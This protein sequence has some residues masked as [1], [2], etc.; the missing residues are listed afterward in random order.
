MELILIRHGTTRGNLERRFIGLTDIPIL[1]E[2]EA[3]AREVSKTLPLVDH[4]YH[5]PLIRCVQTARLLWPDADMTAVDDLHE[6]DFGPFEG[7]SHQE[8]KDD[9]RY[10]AW[11]D[12]AGATAPPGGRGSDRGR[13]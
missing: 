1:P 6:T 13:P 12:S 8:L 9:P 5:S 7:K 3:L 11:L 10:R 4:V 2:G